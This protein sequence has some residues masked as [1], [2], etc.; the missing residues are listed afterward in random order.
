MD[1]PLLLGYYISMTPTQCRMGRAALG[2]SMS[3]L[4]E[5]ASVSINTV[6]RFEQGDDARVSSVEKLRLAMELRSIRFTVSSD[7]G[8]GVY[9]LAR[10]E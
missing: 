6:Q 9:L 7:G 10:A 5:N 2:W 3:D 4:A 1:F 8:Q